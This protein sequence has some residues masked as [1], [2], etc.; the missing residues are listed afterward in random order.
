MNFE[1]N[2]DYNKYKKKW[3]WIQENV[4][5]FFSGMWYFCDFCHTYEW[6]MSHVWM[7]HVTHMN[8]SCRTCEWV[9]TPVWMSHVTH[10]NGSCHTCEWV[11]PHAWISPDAHMNELVTRMSHVTHMKESRHTYEWDMS[12]MWMSQITHMHASCHTCHI[13]RVNVSLHE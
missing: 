12:H 10:M 3:S 1:L 5:D 2:I 11:L 4:R 6:V 13:T 7:S 9:S 8:K